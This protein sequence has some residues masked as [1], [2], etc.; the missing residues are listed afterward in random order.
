MFMFVLSLCY[1][2]IR[3]THDR[4]NRCRPNKL[5]I[6]KWWPLEVMYCWCWSG[7][8][9]HFLR[10]CRIGDFTL[11]HTVTRWLLRHLEKWPTP[12]RQWIHNILGAIRQTPR[13]MRIRINPEIRTGISDHFRLRL[14][15]WWSL[16]SLRAVE[17]IASDAS[18]TSPGN[19]TSYNFV[20][21][22]LTCGC[23][24]HPY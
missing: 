5:G 24:K 14:R 8:L 17:L 2:V 21:V 13:R 18:V 20:T 10:H 23:C 9:F 15:P 11:S 16:R 12:T 6:G 19:V 3:I 22:E 4:S 1:S 7:S